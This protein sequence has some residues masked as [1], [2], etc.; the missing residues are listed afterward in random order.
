LKFPASVIFGFESTIFGLT[1]NRKKEYLNL[2]FRPV[3]VIFTGYPL[4]AHR[5]LEK[6]PMSGVQNFL[7]IMFQIY[8]IK[9]QNLK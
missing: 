4:D 3:E 7:F 2:R 8:Q 9:F 5:I 6:C 1:N